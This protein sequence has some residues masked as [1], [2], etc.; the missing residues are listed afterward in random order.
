MYFVRRESDQMLARCVYRRYDGPYWDE[1]LLKLPVK[2]LQHG[3]CKHTFVLPYFDIY[4][5]SP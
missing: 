1:P 5:T 2:P 3:R 4:F